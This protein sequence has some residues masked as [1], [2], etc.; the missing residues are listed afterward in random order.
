[1]IKSKLNKIDEIKTI[2]IKLR[3][4]GLNKTHPDIKKFQDIVKEYIHSNESYSGKIRITDTDRVLE[5]ILPKT[6][7]HECQVM[8]RYKP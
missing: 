5:Y 1:M 3:Q 4:F 6:N 2:Y 8:L 7:K